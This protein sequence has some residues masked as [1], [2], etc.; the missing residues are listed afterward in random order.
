MSPG[1]DGKS[2]L[3]AATYYFNPRPGSFQAGQHQGHQA[4]LYSDPLSLGQLESE[5]EIPETDTCLAADGRKGTCYEANECANKG[6]MPMGHC[7]AGSKANGG[8][9]CCLCKLY[10]IT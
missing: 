2:P 3:V 7:A 8:S 4:A 6:G 5:N 1:R 10:T 9:V